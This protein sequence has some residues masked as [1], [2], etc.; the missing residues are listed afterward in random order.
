MGIEIER[1]FLVVGDGW[2][3]GATAAALRQG[4]LSSTPERIVRVRLEGE[5]GALTVKGLSRGATRDE[6]EYEIPAADAKDM[7]E[8]LC[9]RPLLEKTRWTLEH[10]GRTWQVDQ[11]HGENDGLVVAEVE[12]ARESD[13]VD[14][15]PWAGREVT[16]DA[17]YYNVSLVRRPYRAWP[18]DER[19]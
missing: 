9:E 7:L 12:L 13:V 19:G 6:F 8:R 16:G 1:K 5:R 4:Y 10:A 11:F 14:L 17:R 18:S 2:R 3:S 15:P